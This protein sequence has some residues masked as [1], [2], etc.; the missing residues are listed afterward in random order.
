M[1]RLCGGALLNRLYLSGLTIAAIFMLDRV[2]KMVVADHLALGE[3]V[4]VI[5]GFFNIVHVRNTGAA[6]GLFSG[7]ALSAVVLAVV[8]LVA[9]IMLLY[10]M[11]RSDSDM[12]AFGLSLI[13]GGALG[14]LAD[15]LLFGEVVDFLD[16]HIAQY[17]WPAFNVADSAITTGVVIALFSLYRR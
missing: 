11:V 8:S 17:H 12:L 7:G 16:F 1:Q 6:F 14:N 9:V 2:S 10:Y 15:R 4:P 5:E 13:T 3:V